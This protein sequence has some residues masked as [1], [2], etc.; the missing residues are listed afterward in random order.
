ML[1]RAWFNLDFIWVGA[2]T[3]AGG[4]ALLLGLSPLA[5]S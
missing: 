5:G 1:R 3:I 4:V 2:L